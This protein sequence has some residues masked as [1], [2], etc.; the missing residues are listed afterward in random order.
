[1]KLLTTDYSFPENGG[2]YRIDSERRMRIEEYQ[3]NVGLSDLKSVIVSMSS[4]PSWSPD[5]HGLVDFSGASLELSANDV[6]R[7]ALVLRHEENRS[8]GWMAFVA[9]DTTT[10]GIVRMLGYWSRSTERLRIF[11]SRQEAERWLELNVDQVP[12]AFLNQPGAAVAA[13]RNAV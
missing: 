9:T 4:D 13:L 11:Q 10:Y 2:R 8:T 1:M 6:L 5:F 12:P 7:L 3:G